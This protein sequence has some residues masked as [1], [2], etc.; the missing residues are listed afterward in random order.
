MLAPVK[1]GLDR[2]LLNPDSRLEST[3][4]ALR[5][6]AGQ[7][8]VAPE[9]AVLSPRIAEFFE[10]AALDNPCLAMD[11]GLVEAA[12]RALTRAFSG[13]RVHYAVKANP[14][15]AVVSRLVGAGSAF[16]CASIAEIKLCLRHGAAP[17]EIGYGNTIKKERDIA[18]AHALGVRLFAFDSA[19]ELE[20]IARAAPGA[21]VFCRV[22]TDGEGAEWPLSRKFGCDI[23]MAEALLIRAAA[24][25]LDAAGVSFHVGSQQTDVESWRPVLKQVAGLFSRLE[26]QGLSP[27]LINLGGGMPARYS[28]P[29]ADIAAYGTAV[30]AAV[31][32][33]FAGRSPD[34]PLELMVEPG[35]GLVG[36]A[37]VI[38]AEVVLVSRKSADDV[39]RW[40]YLDI[41]KFS[42][43]AE[44]MDEAIKYRLLTS[45][46]GDGGAR[47][48]V[49]LAGPTCDSA[50][51]LYER[52]KYDLPFGLR[53]GD[54]VWIMGAGAY[55]ATYAS[56]GFNGFAPLET[57]C[58]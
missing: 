25:G 12:Y 21:T 22:L 3:E 41:G 43:L 2:P 55:T 13:A 28:N 31:H 4:P 9:V 36:D 23:A 19:A 46:D 20:K 24:L 49:I 57:V 15:D 51:V 44:T 11:V 53:D 30:M 39:V 52:A 16:D 34:H 42:G 35:R 58:V 1:G 54:K 50:D 38:Q 32:E 56:V 40:V 29:V 5:L 17:S 18:A 47:G 27:R 45:R 33:I 7:S 26:A 8:V 37:G 14:A 6:V 10:T 48:P